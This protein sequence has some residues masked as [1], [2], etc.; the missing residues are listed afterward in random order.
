[1]F[2]QWVKGLL[3]NHGARGTRS[4]G[5][6]KESVTCNLV[7]PGRYTKPSFEG[8]SAHDKKT[9]FTENPNETR[10]GL[11]KITPHWVETLSGRLDTGN[12]QHLRPWNPCMSC[13]NSY[14]PGPTTLYYRLIFGIGHTS[15]V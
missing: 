13:F 5:Q 12:A 9:I 10:D 2:R 1:M 6:G 14:T 3:K 8:R 4:H 7:L 15:L 11:L